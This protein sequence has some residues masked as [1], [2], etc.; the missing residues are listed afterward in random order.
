[1][2][3]KRPLAWLNWR[4]HGDLAVGQR[5]ATL[6][7]QSPDDMLVFAWLMGSI[8]ALAAVLFWFNVWM[9]GTVVEILINW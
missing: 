1:M 8:A 9:W 7:R 5:C 6:P 3:R 2:N 4:R